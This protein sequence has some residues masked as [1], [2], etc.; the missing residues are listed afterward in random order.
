MW[1]TALFF[2]QMYSLQIIWTGLFFAYYLHLGNFTKKCNNKIPNEKNYLWYNSFWTKWF[3]I[4]RKYK[5]TA[6][7][8]STGSCK[9]YKFICEQY[10]HWGCNICIKYDKNIYHNLICFCATT[11]LLITIT[12]V[13]GSRTFQR[14]GANPKGGA[15]TYYLAIFFLKTAWK[16]RNFGPEGGGA[17]HV[18]RPPQI[19]HCT[20]I[21]VAHVW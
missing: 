4:I 11:H 12:S 13:A 17:A 10:Y 2:D 19:R 16:W 21:N 1:H 18:P 3:S 15:P 7:K 8:S 6:D 9:I 20:L 5:L 14:R